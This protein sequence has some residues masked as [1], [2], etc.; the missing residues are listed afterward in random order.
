MAHYCRSSRCPPPMRCIAK[1]RGRLAIALLVGDYSAVAGAVQ[2]PT[3]FMAARNARCF[4]SVACRTITYAAKSDKSDTNAQ[5]RANRPGK[6]HGS[7]AK[8][9]RQQAGQRPGDAVGDILK[10]GIAAE[11]GAA[12]LRRNA[13]HY[14]HAQRR[15]NKRTAAARSAPHRPAPPR[16]SAPVHSS[17]RPTASISSETIATLTPPN[18]SGI[19]PNSTRISDKGAAKRRQRKAGHRPAYGWRNRGKQR[20]RSPQSRHPAGARPMP[21]L[22]DHAR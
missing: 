21:W 4:L 9:G 12:H 20:Y 2:L 14:F 16:H 11:R 13:L 6:E 15:E 7:I 5:H 18:R 22:P 8:R 3:T 19:Q 1:K 17:I 10:R